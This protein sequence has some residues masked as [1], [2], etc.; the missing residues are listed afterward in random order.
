MLTA[1][2]VVFSVFTL[3]NIVLMVRRKKKEKKISKK[4]RIISKKESPSTDAEKRTNKP[5]F[6]TTHALSLGGAGQ[7]GPRQ[8]SQFTS[9]SDGHS[10]SSELNKKKSNNG[11]CAGSDCSDCSD[12]SDCGDCGD[13]GNCS[14]CRECSEG[15]EGEQGESPDGAASCSV[16]KEQQKK[17]QRDDEDY[18][19]DEEEE[20]ED[21]E[22]EDDDES[23]EE[24]SHEDDEEEEED[25]GLDISGILKEHMFVVPKEK[26][27]L[28]LDECNRIQKSDY[29]R[30]LDNLFGELH[31]FSIQCGLLKEE[32]IALWNECLEDIAKDLK[33][34]DDYYDEIYDFNMNAETVVTVSFVYSLTNFLNLWTTTIEG[35]EKKWCALFAERALDYKDALREAKLRK[36]ATAEPDSQ[37]GAAGSSASGAASTTSGAASTTSGAAGTTSGAAGTTSG[38]AGTTSGA[39]SATS[40]A[41][42]A[43]SSA[44]AA[45]PAQEEGKD[46]QEG[47]KADSQEEGADS[48]ETKEQ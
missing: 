47:D 11:K 45:A 42:S 26:V 34:I 40:G 4:K 19:D 2:R 29:E 17:T 39:A 6:F 24:E 10:T 28:L 9:D 35:I 14:E 22:E 27:E 20:E 15:S 3:M 21:D 31:D 8:L 36:A 46:S 33:D 30:A 5:L 13:C 16:K 43:T 23:N 48:N 12:G 37:E 32:K 7:K 25:G 18:D 1:P 41:A 38:A 44:A